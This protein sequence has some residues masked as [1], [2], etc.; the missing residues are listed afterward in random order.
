MNAPST[1][2]CNPYCRR[3]RAWSSACR[4]PKGWVASLTADVMEGVVSEK[5]CGQRKGLRQLSRLW[6][7]TR[8]LYGLSLVSCQLC[9]SWKCTSTCPKQF[10]SINCD[11]SPHSPL[12]RKCFINKHTHTHSHLYIHVCTHE[13]T[14][15]LIL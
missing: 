8:Y 11:V 9:K 1:E 10:H 7:I 2:L 13:Y 15:T 5:L 14:H 12:Q 6:F 3:L 4:L